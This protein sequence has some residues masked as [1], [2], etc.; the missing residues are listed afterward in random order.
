MADTVQDLRSVQAHVKHCP[1]QF[2]TIE[3]KSWY[4]MTSINKEYEFVY[5][6]ILKRVK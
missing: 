6:L 1:K 4:S 5:H 2:P 3:D